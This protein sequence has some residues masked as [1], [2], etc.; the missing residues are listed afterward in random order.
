MQGSAT[1][2][3]LADMHL[4][5]VGQTMERND[6]KVQLQGVS[7]ETKEQALDLTFEKLAERLWREQNQLSGVL[8]TGDAQDRGAPGGHDQLFALLMKHFARLGISPQKI[9][10]TPG[11]HDV[12]K[13][14][15]PG[16][17][18]RYKAF[19]DVWRAKNC[20]TPWLDGIDSSPADPKQHSLVADDNLWAVFPLNSSN[21]A[22]SKFALPEGVDRQFND[23]AK[24]L[25]ELA[26][27]AVAAEI[28]AIFKDSVGPMLQSLTQVDVARLSGQQLSQI[29]PV[30][31][32][33]GAEGRRPLRLILMH[34]HLSAP[35]IAEEIRPFSEISNLSYIRQFLR[36]IKADVVLHGHKH[37]EALMYDYIYDP[38]LGPDAPPHRLMTISGGTFE[39]KESLSRTGGSAIRLVRLTGLPGAPQVEVERIPL[40][41]P[42]LDLSPGSIVRGRLWR[43][44]EPMLGGPIVIHGN[45]IDEVYARAV[46]A[47]SE[48]AKASM[49]IVHLDQADDPAQEGVERPLPFPADYPE[50]D[51]T[52]P[53]NTQ[54]LVQ[55]L[56]SWWQLPRSRLEERIPY[57]HGTRLRRFGG[58]IDQIS[59]L[60]QL[61]K[62]NKT[63]SRGVATL[64][65]PARDFTLD[66]KGEDF[67][68]FCLVQF[69]RRSDPE[70]GE[71]L[72]CTAYYRAQEFQYWWPINV[73]ELR[74]VQREIA[75]KIS[76][77]PGRITT[78]TADARAV[79]TR[80]PSQVA[81][82][83]IDRWLDQAPEKLARLSQ[84]LVDKSKAD[85]AEIAKDWRAFLISQERA[86]SDF[87][88]EGTAVAVDG[89][90]LLASFVEQ[91]SGSEG[92]VSL[93][94]ALRRLAKANQRYEKAGRS[95]AAFDEWSDDVREYIQELRQAT[96]HVVA[97]GEPAPIRTLAGEELVSA[98]ASSAAESTEG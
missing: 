47:A 7:E 9:V 61:L 83:V 21:W 36:E 22:Q 54:V 77:R 43:T 75:S 81:V 28:E 68:S 53:E 6:A 33:A 79:M 73:A 57:I 64:I 86:A 25:K 42:A 14:S 39:T 23:V 19:I 30:I 97:V 95:P 1:F 85:N 63:T 89:L 59:R 50:I 45:D 38:K 51:L 55:D 93:P 48:E 10:V 13:N 3:H 35:S 62:E 12:V 94:R 78:I 32:A 84:M 24:K 4:T 8:F 29:R 66:G 76:C 60:A 69:R 34:H 56:V 41:V 5:Q 52:Q 92:N 96:E 90:N 17:E 80:S 18:E 44:N 67:A 70:S 20:V 27:A 88:P 98:L 71:V 72:D 37:V 49:L 2:L 82:P 74:S 46:Q 65:D 16:S 40:A 31:E 58:Q 11:N 26:P 87:N 91:L 15:E